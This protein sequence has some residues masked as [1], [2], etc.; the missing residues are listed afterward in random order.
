[1]RQ[2]LPAGKIPRGAYHSGEFRQQVEQYPQALPVDM[3][4]IG[5]SVAAVNYPPVAL[6]NRLAELGLN[7]FTT[8]NA[9]IRGCNY[10]CI[11]T[12]IRKHYLPDFKPPLVLAVISPADLNIDNTGVV[13]RSNRFASDMERSVVGRFA[14]QGL[15]YISYLYGFKEE[16]RDWLTLGGW[17]FDPAVFG[18]RGEPVW[19]PGV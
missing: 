9:G 11:A 16:A 17:T 4:I 12:G 8:Y 18:E 1:M 2:S 3:I 7:K 14:R 10:S 6:D 15:S 19:V 5:S 13:D